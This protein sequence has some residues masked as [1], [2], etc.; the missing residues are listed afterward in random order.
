MKQ[1]FKRLERDGCIHTHIPSSEYNTHT[2]TQFTRF[3]QKGVCV[4]SSLFLCDM[5]ADSHSMHIRVIA[6]VCMHVC[7]C[8]NMRAYRVSSSQ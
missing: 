7:V 1:L 4:C 5:I 2:V 8:V 3:D 6:C